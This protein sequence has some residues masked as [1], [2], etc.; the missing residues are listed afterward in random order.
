M[1]DS[2]TEKFRDIS[3]K[4]QGKYIP[5]IKFGGTNKYI[6][7]NYT[8][9]SDA[10]N[11]ISFTGDGFNTNSTDIYCD[12]KYGVNRVCFSPQGKYVAGCGTNGII[13][14]YDLYENKLLTKI[15]T[16]IDNIRDLKISDND[17]HIYA[18]GDN[19]IIEIFDLYEGR[20]VF[21]DDVARYVDVSIPSLIKSQS[22]KTGQNGENEETGQE[23]LPLKGG[24][25]NLLS[26]MYAPW[27]KVKHK[28]FTHNKVVY[29]PIYNYA[30][31]IKRDI[32]MVD[33]NSIKIRKVNP[34]INKSVFI[35]KDSHDC[36]TSCLAVPNIS[37]FL[38]YSGGGD[39]LLKIWDIRMNSFTLSKKE[40]YKEA[41]S[42]VTFLDSTNPYASICSHEDILTS[43]SFNNTIDYEGAYKK[44]RIVSHRARLARGRKQCAADGNGSQMGK[45]SP[46]GEAEELFT[47]QD[48]EHFLDGENS[49]SSVSSSCS[50]ASYS[51]VT[52]D[53]T[54]NKLNNVLMTSG[55]DGYIRL[56]DIN[57]N[58]IKSFYDE[59]KSI[60][61]C[62]FS[63]N[64]KYI[65]STNKAKSAKIFDFIYMNNKKN[66][67]NMVSYLANYKSYHLNKR[68]RNEHVGEDDDENGNYD[69]FYDDNFSRDIYDKEFQPCE[70]KNIYE[71]KELAEK[72]KLVNELNRKI[73]RGHKK[74]AAGE[75]DQGENVVEDVVEI[76]SDVTYSYTNSSLFDESTIKT[77][78]FYEHVNKK[79]EP[80]WF[81]FLDNLKYMNLIPYDRLNESLR[82]N[83]QY[84][85]ALYRKLNHPSDNS[86]HNPGEANA[87]KQ[88][89]HP[90]KDRMEYMM[91]CKMSDII[92]NESH[93]PNFY[94]CVAG[95]KCIIPS[96]DTYAHV[97]DIYTGFHVNTISNLYLP[98][99][100]YTDYS[101]FNS[102][103][104][105]ESFYKR[106]NL[107][108]L[109]SVDTYPKNQNI[110]A[111]SNGYPDGSLVLWVFAP[112]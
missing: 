49:S 43:I 53:L 70:I 96:L 111:T 35:I 100:H 32:N 89:Y 91:Y 61:H 92:N 65:I 41:K 39:G 3:H 17:K 20:K 34:V 64:N 46:S 94:S 82:R 27:M 57:N 76:E 77:N 37:N 15:C 62:M 13:Y 59:D 79:L 106:R 26:N 58:I 90:L 103:S 11:N 25:K 86:Y 16:R 74:K 63:H 5:V 84:A 44:R 99:Y 67:R 95:D 105:K 2:D 73:S 7:K 24:R 19:Q 108:F 12:N 60:T 50:S 112:F 97:Y 28:D 29:V 9:D 21:N 52:F 55:Y 98:N 18:C 22:G 14:V 51:S 40:N 38:L 6:N 93:I 42:N 8:N 30:D 107:S 1:I 45:E 36:S 78:I 56:Y 4:V 69:N 66:A 48:E 88:I 31:L 101:H 109:T 110:V 72:I 102:S 33:L 80:T 81:L 47:F 23:K 87:E 83:H 75:G 85:K 71:D 104:M 54:R 10:T 68:R